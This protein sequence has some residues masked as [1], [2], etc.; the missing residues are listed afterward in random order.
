MGIYIEETGELNS[1]PFSAIDCLCDTKP[2]TQ[3]NISQSVTHKRSPMLDT[4]RSTMEN[5]GPLPSITGASGSCV[6]NIQ[7]TDI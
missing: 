2:D 3:T 4:L 5:T 1:V 7:A 6:V